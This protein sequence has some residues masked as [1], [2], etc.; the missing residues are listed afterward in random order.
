MSEGHRSQ[1]PEPTFDTNGDT[2]I[3]SG[4]LIAGV[5]TSGESLDGIASDAAIS[6]TSKGTTPVEDKYSNT[7]DGKIN[8]IRET[9]GKAGQGRVMWRE[10]R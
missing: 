7:S 9:A 10:V 6:G 4:D 5:N 2:D 8:R 1:R 3:T